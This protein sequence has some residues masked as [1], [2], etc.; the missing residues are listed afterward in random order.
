VEDSSSLT[1]SEDSL[2]GKVAEIRVA[3]NVSLV[4][5]SLMKYAKVLYQQ[6]RLP[7]FQ[8]VPSPVSVRISKDVASGAKVDE[9]AEVERHFS[10]T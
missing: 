3:A 8:A 7:K 5:R 6:R 1:G 2:V 4:A 9:N 10:H